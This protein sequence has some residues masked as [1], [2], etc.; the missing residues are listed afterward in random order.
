MGVIV[1]FDY[2]KLIAQFPAMAPVGPQLL[3]VY[4][5]IATTMHGNDGSGPIAKESL[6]RSL[7]NM[8]TAHIAQ[9]FAPKDPSGNP[10]AAGTTSIGVV[11]RVQSATEGSVSIATAALEGFNTAQASWLGQTQYGALYWAA[12]AQFRTMR[13][14]PPPCG[15]YGPYST[16]VTPLRWRR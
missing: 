8:L 5:D 14:Q 12:T 2:D 7:L 13:Y 10:S 6:Q 15:I 1:A 3:E 4:W 9:L 11:G 16:V